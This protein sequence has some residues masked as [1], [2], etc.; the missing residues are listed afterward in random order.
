MDK[1]LNLEDNLKDCPRGTK[2]YSELDEEVIYKK[3][4]IC[5]YPIYTEYATF[6]SKDQHDCSKFDKGY[7]AGYNDA[8]EAT[9]K[10]YCDNICDYGRCGMCFHK[11][12]NENQIKK[13]FQYNECNE[14]KIIR[15]T[16]K[17]KKS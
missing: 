9:C 14:L 2:L 11:Y 5:N 17:D 13:T 1:N 16:L 15:G 4:D 7:E 6:P 12:D 3:R 10:C 8:V